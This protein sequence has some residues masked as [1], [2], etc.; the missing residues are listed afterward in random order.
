MTETLRELGLVDL[1]VGVAVLASLLGALRARRGLL[2]ALASALGTAVLCWL[3]AAALLGFGP[4][5]ASEAVSA[6]RLFALLPP[7]VAAVEQAVRLGAQLLGWLNSGTG[8]VSR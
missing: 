7:P 2:G 3:G 8:D 1:V 5:V 4:A 6:S